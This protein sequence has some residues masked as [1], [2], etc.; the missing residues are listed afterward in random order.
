MF[1]K[2]KK[3]V[4]LEASCLLSST[5]RE[6]KKFLILFLWG[7]PVR[8]SFQWVKIFALWCA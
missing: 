2:V 5:V 4:M 6:L 7:A 3:N 8:I 1:A